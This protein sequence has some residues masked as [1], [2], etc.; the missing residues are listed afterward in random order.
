MLI[1]YLIGRLEINCISLIWG[2]RGACPPRLDE[3][4]IICSYTNLQIN[5]NYFDK[6]AINVNSNWRRTISEDV[7][8]NI[9]VIRSPINVGPT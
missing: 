9:S 3:G 1:I 7:S 2:V 4:P 6:V 8:S 5:A